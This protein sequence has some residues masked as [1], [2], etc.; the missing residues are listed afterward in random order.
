MTWTADEALTLRLATPEDAA[1]LHR[2]AALDSSA[3]PELPVLVAEAGDELLAALS[4][5]DHH[6]VADPFR[7]TTDVVALLRERAHA[8]RRARSPRR[9]RPRGRTRLALAR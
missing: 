7:R 1:A 8:T 5:V 6:V 4:L 9:S 2:L 3:A